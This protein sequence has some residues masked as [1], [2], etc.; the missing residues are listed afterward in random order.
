MIADLQ[1]EI[2]KGDSERKAIQAR[3]NEALTVN[4]DYVYLYT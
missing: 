3:L 4:T 1:S 2:R